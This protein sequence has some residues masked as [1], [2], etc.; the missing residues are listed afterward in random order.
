MRVITG[1]SGCVSGAGEW[2]ADSCLTTSAA[3]DA[4]GALGL[5]A[6][7]GAG[8]VRGGDRARRDRAHEHGRGRRTSALA[9]PHAT[10]VPPARTGR[11]RSRERADRHG[12]AT[13]AR[14]PRSG[15]GVDVQAH[16]V[17]DHRLADF[18]ENVV[19]ERV[20]QLRRQMLDVRAE[21]DRRKELARVLRFAR[22]RV[23][24]QR[25]CAKPVAARSRSV[26][27]GPA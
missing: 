24:Q 26:S 13:L 3:H 23:S 21:H 19:H 5:P 18:G 8:G 27:S 11:D 1:S 10:T 9:D 12:S 17:D 22:C 15:D 6:H 2:L 25:A 16:V 14:S 20:A 7:G 4:A